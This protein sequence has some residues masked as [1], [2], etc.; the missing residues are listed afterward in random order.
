[1]Q[2]LFKAPKLIPTQWGYDISF[3]QA[4]LHGED[5]KFLR[6]LNI[7]NELLEKIKRLEKPRQRFQE[8]V[9]EVNDKS[10]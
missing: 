3:S 8:E 4:A 5:G 10:P 2:L 9:Q 1:M 6:N 7:N